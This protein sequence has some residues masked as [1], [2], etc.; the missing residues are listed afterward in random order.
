MTIER[1]KVEAAFASV[2][3]HGNNGD[4]NAFVDHFS[5]DCSFFIPVLEAPIRGLENLRTFSAG[6][7]NVS[8]RVEW[9]AIDGNR[10][11]CAWNTHHDTMNPM[12]SNR[13]ISGYVLR[14]HSGLRV[15]G[16][17]RHRCL[18]RL[19]EGPELID[20]SGDSAHRPTKRCSRDRPAGQ[21]N[22]GSLLAFNH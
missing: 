3:E 2:H 21:G 5:A 10:I 20:C 13:G 4:W 6:F 12:G 1:N 16:M 11:V 9:V 17:V 19:D 18:C 8:N 7:P 22:F 15:R 14:Q